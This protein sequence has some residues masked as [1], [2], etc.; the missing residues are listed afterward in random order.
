MIVQAARTIIGYL[1]LN[2]LPPLVAHDIEYQFF[3]RLIGTQDSHAVIDGGRFTAVD[4]L[5]DIAFL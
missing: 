5:N 4:A 1:D 3:A 2:R